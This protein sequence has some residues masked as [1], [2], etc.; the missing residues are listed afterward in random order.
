M[1]QSAIIKFEKPVFTKIEG[2]V[3]QVLNFNAATQRWAVQDIHIAGG[4]RTIE[5]LD[6]TEGMSHDFKTFNEETKSKVSLYFF[7]ITQPD[8]QLTELLLNSAKY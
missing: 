1:K 7:N 3:H 8:N 2:R 5:M 6:T 4:T